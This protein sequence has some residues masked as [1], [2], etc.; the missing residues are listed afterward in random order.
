MRGNTVI[1]IYNYLL[2]KMDKNQ[3]Y[4]YILELLWLPFYLWRVVLDILSI[5]FVRIRIG[6]NEE[7]MVCKVLSH[8]VKMIPE[9]IHLKKKIK[10]I[11]NIYFLKYFKE[12]ENNS[13]QNSSL[14]PQKYFLEKINSIYYILRMVKIF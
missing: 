9:D 1:S 11:L 3:L 10:A 14:F 5:L 4:L 8:L 7:D 13:I 12:N 6:K 2:K